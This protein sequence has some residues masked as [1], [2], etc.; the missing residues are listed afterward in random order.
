VD[1]DRLEDLNLFWVLLEARFG[2]RERQAADEC[3]GPLQADGPPS[4]LPS[5]VQVYCKPKDI[6][7]P[8]V[9]ELPARLAKLGFEVKEKTV[10]IERYPTVAEYRTLEGALKDVET[11]RAPKEYEISLAGSATG[12]RLSIWRYSNLS[13]QELLRVEFTGKSAEEVV[14]KVIS[15][16]GLEPD[17]AAVGN[18]RL[19]RTCFVG[20]RFD[21]Q[22]HELAERL[23]RFL[24]L[25]R[26]TISTGREFAPR[27]ISEKVRARMAQQSIV[28]AILTAGEDK[29]WLVQESLLGESSGKS[30]FLLKEKGYTHSGALLADKEYIPF[31]APHIEATFV[32]VLEGLRELGFG[33]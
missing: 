3:Q 21:D 26:F 28:F 10:R 2:L 16:L 30:L 8:V 29:T 9:P 4:L 15:F 33:L 23:C 11:N 5:K 17:Q 25:L 1:V 24:R 14:G 20:Y 22:G 27:S 12:T 32:Q 19:E 18:K 13:G 7:W 6:T 31:E